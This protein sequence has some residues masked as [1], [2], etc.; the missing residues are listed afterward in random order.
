MRTHSQ[1]IAD[2]GGPA[3][4]G[5]IVGAEANTAKQ[6][7]RLDSIPS[8]HWYALVEAGKA[9][10]AELGKAAALKAGAS[11]DPPTQDVAA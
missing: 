6:W 4:I 5:K 11:I 9:S 7:K 3:A 10:W 1:I 2:I 8:K